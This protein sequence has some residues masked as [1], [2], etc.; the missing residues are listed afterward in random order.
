GLANRG[1]GFHSGGSR[2]VYLAPG[3]PP[4]DQPHRARRFD[5]DLYTAR[6]ALR[7]LPADRVVGG[8]LLLRLPRDSFPGADLRIRA[9]P[10]LWI[11]PRPLCPHRAG[12]ATAHPQHVRGHDECEPIHDRGGTRSRHEC[13]AGF[14]QGTAAVGAPRHPRWHQI[15]L[16]RDFR[17]CNACVVDRREDPGAIHLYRNRPSGYDVP[18][19]RRHSDR[20]SRP[21]GGIASWQPGTGVHAARCV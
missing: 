11:P 2:A 14:F 20:H 21:P 15:G 4:P 18:A 6:C 19:G 17:Q 3:V 16:S 1:L 8:R 9:D 12:G 5:A 10:R 7:P 13:C